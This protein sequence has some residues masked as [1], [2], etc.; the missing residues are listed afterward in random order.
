[1]GFARRASTFPHQKHCPLGYQSLHF[2][3]LQSIFFSNK[4]YFGV[5]AI[6]ITQNEERKREKVTSEVK[7]CSRRKAQ[8]GKMVKQKICIKKPTRLK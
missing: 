2:A 5:I 3:M 4:L 1:M 8:N 6:K 7:E